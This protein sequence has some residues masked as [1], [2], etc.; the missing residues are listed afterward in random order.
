[1]AKYIIKPGQMFNRL[2]VIQEAETI[3][4]KRR[5]LCKCT[6]GEETTVDLYKL[7]NGITKSC[8]CLGRELASRPRAKDLTDQ[9]FGSL[10]AIRR[11][12]DKKQNGSAIWLCECK[13]GEIVP[14]TARDL[15]SGN[16][17]SCGCILSEY[18]RSLKEY[19]EKHHTVDGVFVPLLTQKVQ[20][21]NTT[22]HKGVSVRKGKNGVERYIASI[23]VKKERHYLGIYDSLDEAV[24]AR[25]IAEKKHYKPYLEEKKETNE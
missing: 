16:T 21:N 25:E 6:C 15:L 24:S 18:T 20:S 10:K 12:N 5:V 13:C 8:G 17:K 19:N 23:T 7:R 2:E 4:G 11:D 22:G 3:K 9:V 1:M 14:V